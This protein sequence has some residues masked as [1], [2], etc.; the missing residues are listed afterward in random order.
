MG[1][2]DSGRTCEEGTP[3]LCVVA[4]KSAAKQN[5]ECWMVAISSKTIAHPET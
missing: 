1:F 3:A 5:Q 2:E 4:R